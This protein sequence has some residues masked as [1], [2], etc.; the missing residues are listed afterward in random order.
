MLKAMRPLIFAITLMVSCLGLFGNAIGQQFSKDQLT[1]FEQKIRP[2]LVERCYEC[3]SAEAKETKGGLRLDSREA[4]LT[5]GDNGPA[6]VEENP[7]QSLLITA[8]HYRDPAYEMPPSGKLADREIAV[9]EQW[10]REGLPFPAVSSVAPTKRVI[11]ID[12]GR[13][14]W[15]FQ[16]L[17]P[18]TLPPLQQPS[19][20]PQ[21]QH[22]A[23]C[24]LPILAE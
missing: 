12:A 18:P 6:V 10:V 2:L 15:A 16:K 11:D 17:K 21:G 5:G 8:V 23:R 3:H 13:Q 14:H 7:E 20:W 4:I 19:T 22:E 1:F 9:L 24:R